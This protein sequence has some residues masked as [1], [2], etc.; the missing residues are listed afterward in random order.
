MTTSTTTP[1]TDLPTGRWERLRRWLPPLSLMAVLLPLLPLSL[2]VLTLV[3]LDV[4]DA[5][6]VL[7]QALVVVVLLAGSVYVRRNLRGTST[8]AAFEAWEDGRG[9]TTAV[10]FTYIAIALA[11]VAHW[12][13]GLMWPTLALGLVAGLTVQ[14]TAHRRRS[15]EPR[16]VVPDQQS[17]EP[18][19]DHELVTLEWSL[20]EVRQGLRG[21]VGSWIRL[22]KVQ[23]FRPATNPLTKWET[24]PSGHDRPAFEWYVDQ[25]QCDEV[26]NLADQLLSV[27]QA[28]GLTPYLEICLVL[29]LVQRIEYRSD[30]DRRHPEETRFSDYWRFPLETIADRAGDCEDSAILTVALLSAMG[31]RTCFFELPGHAAVGVQGL[32]ESSGTYVA[33]ADGAWFYYTETTADGYRIGELP[34]GT[35]LDDLRISA[36]VEPL[37]GRRQD[38]SLKRVEKGHWRRQTVATALGALMLA[39]AGGL[40]ALALAQYL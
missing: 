5:D 30:M 3:D 7:V 2:V 40:I 33:A 1:D 23:S 19:D 20:E 28:R 32:P 21:Q 39:L 22:S 31:H 10:P 29:D 14:G 27:S 26:N 36:I 15:P 6:I 16:L 11:I 18:K 13:E 9:T 37:R 38:E 4:T 35:T 25:G 8:G 12:R 34:D 24:G 17:P